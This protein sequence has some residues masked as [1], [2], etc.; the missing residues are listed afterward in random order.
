MQRLS[1]SLKMVRDNPLLVLLMACTSLYV[2]CHSTTLFL[3][4]SLAASLV[5]TPAIYGRCAQLVTGERPS[6]LVA[7][8]TRHGFNFYVVIVLFFAPL[9]FAVFWVRK[10]LASAF[11]NVAFAVAQVLLIFVLPNAFMMKSPV[12]AITSGLSF[13][14]RNASQSLPLLGLALFDPMLH[15]AMPSVWIAL[16]LSSIRAAALTLP[17]ALLYNIVVSSVNLTLFVAAGMTLLGIRHD[18]RS[19]NAY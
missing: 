16:D 11:L 2:T 3:W 19:A 7:L 8:F 10:D 5:L 9:V 15:A 6:P 18:Q 13:L 12:E 4:I 1:Q 14:F 17:L